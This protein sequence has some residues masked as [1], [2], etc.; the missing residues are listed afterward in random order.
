MSLTPL[1]NA[2]IVIQLHAFV[3]LAM[4]PLTAAIFVLPRGKTAHRVLGW[5]WVC[6]MT[7][8]AISSF[9]ITGIRQI[10]PFSFIHALSVVTLI[11]LVTG[12]AAAR[13][14]KIAVH[15]Q[16]MRSLVL[17]A[18]LLAGAFTLLPGRLM[19]AVLFGS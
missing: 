1:L 12:V 16:T 7:I 6:C 11:S 15:R 14:R 10:G 4:A 3:A 19:H 18:L 17:F 9:W 2:P 5:I 8:V 13:R